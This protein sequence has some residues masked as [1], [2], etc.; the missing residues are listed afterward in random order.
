MAIAADSDVGGISVNV[1]EWLACN[2]RKPIAHEQSIAIGL[3]GDDKIDVNSEAIS[4]AIILFCKQ[5]AIVGGCPWK[6][7]GWEG[8]GGHAPVIMP[9]VWL[10]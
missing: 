3:T 7:G 4:E 10:V 8:G 6:I 9:P 1:A 5:H 2:V